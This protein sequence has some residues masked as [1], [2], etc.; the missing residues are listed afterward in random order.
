MMCTDC[1]YKLRHDPNEVR[2]LLGRYPCPRCRKR[3][4]IHVVLK[5]NIF[6][7]TYVRD[8]PAC[9]EWP[10]KC[11]PLHK[12]C[13]GDQCLYAHGDEEL[14][15]WKEMFRTSRSGFTNGKYISN[16]EQCSKILR[17]LVG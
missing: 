11:D 2:P 16:K 10:V 12:V 13:G 9:K 7:T 4:S 5:E 15:N 3:R 6:E 14:D 17:A 1:F 8:R